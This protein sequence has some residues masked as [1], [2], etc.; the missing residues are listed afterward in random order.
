VNDQVGNYLNVDTTR[1][2]G[3]RRSAVPARSADARASDERP[4]RALNRPTSSARIGRTVTDLTSQPATA[5]IYQ[6]LGA[7]ASR[8]AIAHPKAMIT[9]L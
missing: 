2:P 7:N 5:E 3:P 1:R 9:Q 8:H 6:P 4:A